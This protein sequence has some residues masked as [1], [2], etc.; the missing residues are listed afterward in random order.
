MR[1][2]G[3]CL[4]LTLL[5]SFEPDIAAQDAPTDADALRLPRCDASIKQNGAGRLAPDAPGATVAVPPETATMMIAPAP[6]IDSPAKCSLARE[7]A[8]TASGF[9]PSTLDLH[10]DSD[11]RGLT[12]PDA[13]GL[14]QGRGRSL[15]NA[16]G[17]HD[18]RQ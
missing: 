6:A 11:R 5:L 1:V 9:D 17:F 3:P 12:L 4:G 16:G 2:L 8:A 18:R 14:N 7:T 15:G 10:F 13:L